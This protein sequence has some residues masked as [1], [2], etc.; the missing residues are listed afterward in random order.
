[1]KPKGIRKIASK[2]WLGFNKLLIEPFAGFIISVT[3][4]TPQYLRGYSYLILSGLLPKSEKI[5]QANVNEQIYSPVH[6][7]KL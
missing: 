5:L 7:N 4:L 2:P 1:V 3:F 6:S